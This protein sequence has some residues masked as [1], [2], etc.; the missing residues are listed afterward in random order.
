MTDRSLSVSWADEAV[1][2]DDGVA[3]RRSSAGDE[4]RNLAGGLVRAGPAQVLI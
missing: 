1:E 3:E 2:P 4:E